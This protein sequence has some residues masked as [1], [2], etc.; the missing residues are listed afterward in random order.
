M[1][2]QARHVFSFVG[3]GGKSTLLFRFAREFKLQRRRILATTTTHI[4][5]PTAGQCD[6]RFLYD[7]LPPDGTE[8]KGVTVVGSRKTHMGKKLK[9]LEFHQL[10]KLE[11]GFDTILI[12]SDGA[13]QKPIKAP[14][15]H[16]PVIWPKTTHVIGVVGYDSF[17]S[18]IDRHH[19]HRFERFASLTNKRVGDR[20]DSQAVLRLVDSP[21]GLFKNAPKNCMKVWIVNQVDDSTKRKKA[22]AVVEYVLKRSKSPDRVLL[23]GNETE[24][25]YRPQ[26]SH[27]ESASSRTN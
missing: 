10:E 5:Y 12:E 13:A 1:D 11:S 24:S 15:G 2:P 17:G 7:S 19:V 22:K 6:F 4:F 26:G 23:C 25:A 20:V 3:A 14:A 16:E 8:L 18:R 21:E 27:C 9:G